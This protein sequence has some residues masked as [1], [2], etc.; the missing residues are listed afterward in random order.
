LQGTWKEF[1]VLVVISLD[2]TQVTLGMP[3]LKIHNLKTNW[4]DGEYIFQGDPLKVESILIE[5]FLDSVREDP[6]QVF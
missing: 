3:W 2:I 4:V 6:G 1:K 5:D